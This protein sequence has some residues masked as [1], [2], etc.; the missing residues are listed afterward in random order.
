[1][2][3]LIIKEKFH[4]IKNGL[5]LEYFE[6]SNFNDQLSL[7]LSWTSDNFLSV[8][9]TV[10]IDFSGDKPK[11][12]FLDCF[13]WEELKKES[14]PDIES[15]RLLFKGSE[16]NSQSTHREIASLGKCSR[17]LPNEIRQNT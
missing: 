5:V 12:R 3:S 16:G 17:R 4:E 7:Y 6:N 9:K 8:Y 14:D 15:N 10:H 2:R 13:N 11:V 1:V